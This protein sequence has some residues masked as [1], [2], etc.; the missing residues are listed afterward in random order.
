LGNRN[1]VRGSNVF[2]SG[3]RNSAIGDNNVIVNGDH[4]NIMGI[5][6]ENAHIL[7]ARLM[8]PYYNNLFRTTRV[9]V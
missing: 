5:N 6:D 9:R 7:R 8:N 3:N 1:R 2:I 4:N